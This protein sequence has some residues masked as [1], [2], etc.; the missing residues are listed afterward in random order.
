[1]MPE[2]VTN[3][4]QAENSPGKFSVLTID[5]NSSSQNLNEAAALLS[6]FWKK[7]DADW[8]TKNMLFNGVAC[9]PQ[10]G[11]QVLERLRS[12]DVVTMLII[13]NEVVSMGEVQKEK[14]D[15]DIV[16]VP[17]YRQNGYGIRVFRSLLETCQKNDIPEIY[18]H[19]SPVNLAV[20][21]ILKKYKLPRIW[22]DEL[23][24]VTINTKETLAKISRRASRVK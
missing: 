23:F 6:P 3:S 18:A 5:K 20:M 17:D 11:E 8:E 12:K 1:M 24:L 14:H 19:V 22:Q 2:S 10:N 4:P 13:D 21:Y 15:M 9:C 7:I 16:T